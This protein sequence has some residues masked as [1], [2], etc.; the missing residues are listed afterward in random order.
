L[1]DKQKASVLRLYADTL[2]TGIPPVSAYK[3]AG[4]L[5]ANL[6]VVCSICLSNTLL[7][8]EEKP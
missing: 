7:L 3:S 8:V 6:L 1:T 5:V 2:I 4:E